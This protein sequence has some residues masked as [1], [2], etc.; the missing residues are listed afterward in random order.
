MQW[1]LDSMWVTRSFD[2][3]AGTAPSAQV[4]SLRVD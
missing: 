3:I 4:V 2:D 1:K